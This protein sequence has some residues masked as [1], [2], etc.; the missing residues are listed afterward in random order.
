MNKTVSALATAALIMG[1]SSP[2]LAQKKGKEPVQLTTCTQ[3]YGTIAVVEGDTQGWTKY[4]LSSPRELINALAMESGCFTPHNPAG[5][6][7]AD[8]LLNVIAGDAEEVDKSIDL[9]K[10]AA[11][12]GLIRSGAAG[13]L[14][15]RVPMGGALLGAFG[16]LG[17]KKKI[18]AAGIKV[19]SPAT[20]QTIATGSGEVRKSSLTLGGAGGVGG[21]WAQGVQNAGYGTSKDG[22]MLA[23]AFIIAFNAVAAQGPALAQAPK[24]AAPAAAGASVVSETTMR[25]APAAGAAEVRK[26]R[27]GTTL[28]PT[29]KRDGL[30]IEVEDSFGTRGWVS[31]E[32]LG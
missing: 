9:A 14:L 3:A 8:F 29:G 2:A 19:L 6:K 18:V 5:G 23:E 4:G 15:T 16:G 20:G 7:P 13:S 28:T 17:G 25:A 24:A 11:T 10:S 32:Y 27:A 30:F 12:E 1:A 31:V 21:G 26:L 22:K